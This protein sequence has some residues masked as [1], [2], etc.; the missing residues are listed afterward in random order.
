MGVFFFFHIN[1]L[2]NLREFVFNPLKPCGFKSVSAL[3]RTC[4]YKYTY[5]E[6]WDV[7]ELISLLAKSMKT[8]CIIISQSNCWQLN[9]RLWSTVMEE[10]KTNSEKTKKKQKRRITTHLVKVLIIHWTI[11][12]ATLGALTKFESKWKWEN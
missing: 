4:V 12:V 5:K 9:Q 10:G 2:L 7:R 11:S 3:K 1:M 8:E 6:N